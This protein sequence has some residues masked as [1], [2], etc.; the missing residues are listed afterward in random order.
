MNQVWYRIYI[1]QT[2]STMSDQVKS[3]T[4]SC[5]AATIQIQLQEFLSMH[6]DVQ[7][8]QA[9]LGDGAES[10]EEDGFVASQRKDDDYE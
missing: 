3:M 7:A 6:G 2:S 1:E 10:D 4:H 5:L 9:E 8:I